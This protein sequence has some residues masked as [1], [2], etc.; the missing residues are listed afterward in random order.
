MALHWTLDNGGLWKLS[1]LG[2]N[3]FD[4]SAF[5]PSHPL[6]PEALGPM[7]DYP[8]QGRSLYIQISKGL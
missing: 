7:S 3:I 4:K 6:V 8:I 2:K 1:I 5:E